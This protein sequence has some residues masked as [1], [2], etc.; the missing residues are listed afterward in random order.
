MSKKNKIAGILLVV[1][2]LM[3]LL[4]LKSRAE[5]E[6]DW[7]PTI[8]EPSQSWEDYMEEH[9]LPTVEPSPTPNPT[10]R[11]IGPMLGST[12]PY[13]SALFLGYRLEPRTDGTNGYNYQR[14][15]GNFPV[16]DTPPSSVSRSYTLA[17]GLYTWTSAT[18]SGAQYQLN[19]QNSLINLYDNY[20]FYQWQI[21]FTSHSVGDLGYGLDYGKMFLGNAKYDI[22]A[23]DSDTDLPVTG[24]PV[25]FGFKAVFDNGLTKTYGL[26]EVMSLEHL[27]QGI[28]FGVPSDV[29]GRFLNQ[30]Y[31]YLFLGYNDSMQLLGE[32]VD[33]RDDRPIYY[34]V[35][36]S[37]YTI[38]GTM[39][40][41]IATTNN[42]LDAILEV[43][44]AIASVF[45][46]TE[47]MFQDW[48]D[49]KIN[50]TADDSST[51]L[52]YQAYLQIL[53]TM[54]NADS[55]EPN[56]HLKLPPLKIRINGTDYQYFDG[57]DFDMQEANVQLEGQSGSLFY[58]SRLVGDV[59]IVSGFVFGFVYGIWKRLFDV[60]FA[61]GTMAYHNKEDD[62]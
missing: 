2:L 29:E 14:L 50:D 34:M 21:R 38:Q 28:E 58:Y 19:K 10:H 11:P 49:G 9:P 8:P 3:V 16:Y 30:I 32:S 53:S 61:A 33:T 54:A 17:N 57:I 35:K 60:S 55:G 48:I 47:E 20:V 59:I 40:N 26:N 24:I 22:T 18:S 46:P 36:N 13:T 1:V 43:P 45:V 31:V 23:Y 27:K 37:D 5:A 52:Y 7:W 51:M 41:M 44:R 42:L 62:S 12:A 4:G 56:F 6:S 15:T 25:V 39:T